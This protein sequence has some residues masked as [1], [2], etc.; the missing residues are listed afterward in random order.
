M[1][2]S[3]SAA[4]MSIE[5]EEIL[6]HKPSNYQDVLAFRSKTYGTVLALDGVIQCTERDEFSCVIY[7][8]FHGAVFCN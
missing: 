2:P 5:V 8:A 4:A 1:S 7:P 3:N 6:Y